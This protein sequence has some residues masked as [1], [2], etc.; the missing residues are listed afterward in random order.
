MAYNFIIVQHVVEK[1]SDS[2]TEGNR[3]CS[4]YKPF[5]F[6][7]LAIINPM[8]GGVETVIAKRDYSSPSAFI[9]FI[10][11]FLSSEAILKLPPTLPIS[12]EDQTSDRVSP[13][14]PASIKPWVSET[15]SS[16]SHPSQ[17]TKRN[18]PDSPSLVT[19]AKV[20]PPSLYEDISVNRMEYMS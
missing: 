6:P 8:T 12:I 10:T 4:L 17:Q 3:L 13:I 19:P 18:K 16:H 7:Y 1:N 20:P 9:D 2:Q 11:D 15:P 5:S 14:T